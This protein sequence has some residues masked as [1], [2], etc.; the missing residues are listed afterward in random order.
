MSSVLTAHGGRMVRIDEAQWRAAVTD[1]LAHMPERLAFMTPAHHRVRNAAVLG[2]PGN[3]G[4][5]LSIAQVA[6]A[7]RV[8]V[9]QARHL[10]ADLERHLF[11]I[12]RGG[13]DR[14]TWAYPVT[15][16]RTPHRLAFDSGEAIFG[17]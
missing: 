4:A 12:V 1:S 9:G 6:A 2:L 16:D 3:G 13:A 15:A 10:A 14:I 7:A 17:A 5:P 11:F 8:P